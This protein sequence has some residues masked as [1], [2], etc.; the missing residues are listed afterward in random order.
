MGGESYKGG[1]YMKCIK[2]DYFVYTPNIASVLGVRIL[3]SK[4]SKLC[5]AWVLCKKD[6]Y[7][8]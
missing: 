3:C 2:K 1:K 7:A 8:P 5:Y 4:K 6:H